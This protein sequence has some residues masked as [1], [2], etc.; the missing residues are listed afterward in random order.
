MISFVLVWMSGFVQSFLKSF[1]PA[2]LL[3]LLIFHRCFHWSLNV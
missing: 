3:C 1:P 2:P